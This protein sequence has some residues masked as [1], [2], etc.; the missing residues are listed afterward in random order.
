MLEKTQDGQDVIW[1][2]KRQC[3]DER[4]RELLE[5]HV[6]RGIDTGLG[7]QWPAR[8]CQMRM[9]LVMLLAGLIGRLMVNIIGS[10]VYYLKP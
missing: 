7:K 8:R 10:L 1:R 5:G 6:E 2:G 3:I 4:I 9:G